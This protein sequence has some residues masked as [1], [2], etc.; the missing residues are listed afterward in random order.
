M[1]KKL[2]INNKGFTIVEL[3]VVF[4]ITTALASFLII[5]NKAN[6]NQILLSLET[7]KLVDLINKAKSLSISTYTGKGLTCGYGIY[8]D[9]GTNNYTLFKYGSPASSNE[10]NNI[11]S[12]N[13]NNILTNQT[14]YEL[15]KNYLPQNHKFEQNNDF[16]N[17]IFFIPPDPR[18]LIWKNNNALPKTE[19]DP[20]YESNIYLSTKDNSFKKIINLNVAGQ[21]SF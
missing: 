9:Y 3:I 14:Y 21:I 4:A 5:Y 8:I 16:L 19:N 18:V 20:D 13:I 1:K 2:K 12:L 15:E 10:C 7:A 17:M 11:Q 6:N